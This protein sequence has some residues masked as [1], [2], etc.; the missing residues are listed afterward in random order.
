MEQLQ[1]R[2]EP[3]VAIDWFGADLELIPPDYQLA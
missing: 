3:H 1:E 2:I